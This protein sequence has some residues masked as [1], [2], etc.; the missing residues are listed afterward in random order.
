MRVMGLDY[1]RRRLGLSISDETAL[2]A[3]PLA[4]YQRTHSLASDIAHV[5][6]LT[7]SLDAHALVIGLP[8]HMN[9]SRGEMAREVES[10][11]VRLEKVLSVPITLWDERLSSHEAERVLLEGDVK[12]KDRKR[13]RDG[14]A[15]TLILQGYLDHQRHQATPPGASRPES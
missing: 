8:L 2:I 13:L 12:R 11:A 4:P 1:G 14:L 5:A 6:R 15:A 7:R 10:F 9:G 3:R